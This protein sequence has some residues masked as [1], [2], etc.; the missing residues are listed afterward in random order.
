MKS[1]ISL[2]LI[3]FS[4]SAFAYDAICISNNPNIRSRVSYTEVRG[5]NVE[6]LELFD[7]IDF[8]DLRI[9]RGYY[10]PFRDVEAKLL[11]AGSDIYCDEGAYLRGRFNANSQLIL[12]LTCNNDSGPSMTLMSLKLDC[13]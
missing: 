2:A 10:T 9:P 13:I 11:A 4:F 1:L 8:N 12:N 5:G 6:S 7:D 3:F